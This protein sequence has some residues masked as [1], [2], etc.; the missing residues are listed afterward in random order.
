MTSP[1][2]WN[3]GRPWATTSSAV[4]A[5]AS[6]SASRLEVMARRGMTAPFGAPVVPDV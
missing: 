5:H 6:A 2:T 4:H 3:S 1:W